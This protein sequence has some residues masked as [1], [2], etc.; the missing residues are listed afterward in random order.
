M[1]HS[2]D[3][4]TFPAIGNAKCLLPGPEVFSDMGECEKDL[5]AAGKISWYQQR[6]CQSLVI[7]FL[8]GKLKQKG[9][10]HCEG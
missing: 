6:D 9:F 5:L 4:K 8:D 2:G 7:E 1:S 3:R 10:F